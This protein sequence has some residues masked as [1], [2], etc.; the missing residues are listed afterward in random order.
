MT[1]E[2]LYHPC[3]AGPGAPAVLPALLWRAGPGWRMIS[4]AV[5]GGGMGE[6][7]WFLNAQVP[8]GYTRHDPHRHLAGIAAPALTGPSLH[9]APQPPPG[10]GLMT[11]A[12][13][14]ATATHT[15]EDGAEALVTAGVGVSGWAAVPAQRAAPHPGPGTINILVALP[16]PLTDAALVN[17]VTT[18]T[19]A[20]VQALRDNG[21]DASGTP[22]DAVCVAART[23][24]NA[25]PT[26]HFG[27]PRSLW[28]ARLARAVHRA[29]HEAVARDA[30]LRSPAP[31]P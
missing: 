8:H 17:A 14:L 12:D 11:A 26:E 13:V 30:H 6:R 25:T 2:T 9:P 7:H 3:A 18:A 29:T 23:P 5:L 16:V 1:T 28:G 19:E 20:K 10:V 22:T 21:Y 27:G 4:S 31:A 24:G 15:A